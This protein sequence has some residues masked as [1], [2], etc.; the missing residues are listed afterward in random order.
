MMKK[1]LSC[2]VVLLY[3]SPSYADV[4]KWKD[5]NGRTHYGDTTSATAL[6]KPEPA[7]KQMTGS[8]KVKGLSL[9]LKIRPGRVQ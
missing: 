1:T 7:I 3:M 2:L 4:Y 6:Q 8:P 5:A 9:K